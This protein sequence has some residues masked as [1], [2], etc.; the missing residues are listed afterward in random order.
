MIRILVVESIDDEI[1]RSRH[2]ILG[3]SPRLQEY[4][5]SS[6]YALDAEGQDAQEDLLSLMA[7]HPPTEEGLARN[8]RKAIQQATPDFVLLHTGFVFQ[9]YQKVFYSVWSCLRQE[10]PDIRFGYEER[11]GL[12]IIDPEAFD[13]DAETQQMQRLF[14]ERIV[15]G[16]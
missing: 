7:R 16:R 10:F 11:D 5:F 8:M 2:R 14:F 6:C 12:N 9:S 3:N 13:L 1:T 15:L 4:Q